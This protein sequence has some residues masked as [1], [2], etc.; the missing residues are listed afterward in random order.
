MLASQRAKR[1]LL[2]ALASFPICDKKTVLLNPDVILPDPL[3]DLN[4]ETPK[5]PLATNCMTIYLSFNLVLFTYRYR[6][7]WVYLPGFSLNSLRG[8]WWHGWLFY[9]CSA[10]LHHWVLKAAWLFYNGLIC[11]YHEKG[12]WFSKVFWNNLLLK[13]VYQDLDIVTFPNEESQ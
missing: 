13:L 4:Q 6:R 2:S 5:R 10:G 11:N 12:I 9:V 1:S 8:W 7:L 3:P